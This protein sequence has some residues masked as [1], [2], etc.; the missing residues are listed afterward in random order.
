LKDSIKPIS[1]GSIIGF[2]LGILPGAGPVIPPFISY[3]LE[4]RISKHPERFGQGAIEGVAGPEA[5]NNAGVTAAFVPMLTLGIPATA[6]MAILLGALLMFGV[7]PGPLL[8]KKAP[9]IFWGTITSMY[10]EYNA[11]GVTFLDPMG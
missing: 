9:D 1:R 8:M 11:F 5:A 3:I 2:L 10:T 4:K 6:T 7:Q